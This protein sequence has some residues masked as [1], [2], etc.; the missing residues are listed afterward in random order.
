MYFIT[1]RNVLQP[2]TTLDDYKRGLKHVW[3]TL[4]SWG[5][6]KIEMF[7]ELYDESGAFYTRYYVESLDN[8]N[9]HI[10]SPQFTVMLEHLDTVIDLGQ[11]EVAISVE[12]DPGV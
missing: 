11:S 8:W 10:M 4:Q 7:Q 6:T 9:Q 3:P 12:L 5:A 2:E 1:Y